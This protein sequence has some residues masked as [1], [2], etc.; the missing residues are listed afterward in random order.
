MW[1][2]RERWNRWAGRIV[3]VESGHSAPMIAVKIQ[4]KN[5]MLKSAG[6]VPGNRYGR[7]HESR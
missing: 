3:L 7:K 1:P 6:Q 4:G 2:G 5:R